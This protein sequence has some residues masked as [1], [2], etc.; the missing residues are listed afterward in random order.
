VTFRR[1]DDVLV[2]ATVIHS[3]ERTTRV[4]FPGYSDETAWI[5]TRLIIPATAVTVQTEQ[6]NEAT[7]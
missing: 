3:D 2:P 4:R 1:G 6:E 7:S 5:D